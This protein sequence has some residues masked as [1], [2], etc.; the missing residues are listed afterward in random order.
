MTKRQCP[1]VAQD[2]EDSVGAAS[3]EDGQSGVRFSGDTTSRPQPS[4]SPDSIGATGAVHRRNDGLS[5]LCNGETEKTE[6]KF[7][8]VLRLHR[9]R[10]WT[11]LLTCR[12]LCYDR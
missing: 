6:N 4:F 9:S 8:T 7:P 12:S 2:P 3:A 10:S 5:Q 11:R 1:H